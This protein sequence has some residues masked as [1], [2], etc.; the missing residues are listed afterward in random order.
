M[1]DFE[2][3]FD[4][5]AQWRWINELQAY[6]ISKQIIIWIAAF[7]K[8]GRKRVRISDTAMITE[9]VNDVVSIVSAISHVKV[10]TTS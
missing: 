1:F 6:E 5:I 4:K 8:N 2:E 3:A 9:V 10:V 7:S